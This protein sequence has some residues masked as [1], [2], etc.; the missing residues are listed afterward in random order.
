VTTKKFTFMESQRSFRSD[1][2]HR[3]RA[4][5]RPEP[6]P[7]HDVV[8]ARQVAHIGKV[9]FALH[10]PLRALLG[11]V[12]FAH[13]GV[14]HRHEAAAHHRIEVGH[15]DL[16]RGEE[17]LQGLELLGLHADEEA[18]RRIGRRAAPPG[19]DELVARKGE[20]KHR[21][22][23]EREARDLHRVA[24]RVAPQVREPVAQR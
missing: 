21:G 22:Q 10:Q 7:G 4:V 8:V 14:V 2:L 5:V 9:E 20:K 24:A 1:V 17:R 6:A 16:V 19:V 12:R 23:T 15:I 18:V 3:Q 13:R 11:V